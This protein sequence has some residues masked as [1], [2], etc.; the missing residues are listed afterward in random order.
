MRELNTGGIL[1]GLE[2]GEWE[3]TTHHSHVHAVLEGEQN[4]CHQW[5]IRLHVHIF[6]EAHPL[7]PGPP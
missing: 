2:R 5:S 4:A 7:W 3:T 1:P 6:L